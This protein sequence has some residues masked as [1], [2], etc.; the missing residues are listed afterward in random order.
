MDI[1][2]YSNYCKHSQKVLQ[3]LV[4]GGMSESL[5]FICVDKRVRDANNNQLYIVLEN[6][7]RVT[8]PP[9]IQSV[10]ALLQVKKNYSVI[11]GDDIIAHFG[12]Q[13]ENK[14]AVAHRGGGEPMAFQLSPSGGSNIVSE[15][16]T[17]YNMTSDELSAK[18]NG[19]RRQLYNYVPAT[20]D[21]LT[22]PTPPDNYQPDKISSNVTVDGLQQ[23]RNA[24]IQP[25]A[26]ASFI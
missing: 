24:D 13:V 4:K 3:Y 17:M 2:Y 1:L 14:V 8:M 6:G 15:Q 20:H 22:I 10:P 25:S 16:Y 12:P 7:K 23:K 21:T 9:N 18:G 26:A 11:L 5:N 19:G